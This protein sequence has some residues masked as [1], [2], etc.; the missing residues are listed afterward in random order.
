MTTTILLLCLL[1]KYRIAVGI[2]R[3][4]QPKLNWKERLGCIGFACLDM[5]K[6]VETFLTTITVCFIQVCQTGNFVSIPTFFSE[7]YN[8]EW[9]TTHFKAIKLI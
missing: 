2:L 9:R 4:F 5:C 3:S 8:E 6:E 7:A 1:I